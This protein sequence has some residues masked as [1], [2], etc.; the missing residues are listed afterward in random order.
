MGLLDKSFL[1]I[2][3]KAG[4][5]GAGIA[6]LGLI[7]KTGFGEFADGQ[8]VSAQT[9]AVL[10]STGGVAGVTAKSIQTLAGAIQ[11]K[12]GIDDEAIQAGQNLL[13]TFTNIRNETGKGNKIFDQATTAIT[14]MSVAL[15]QDMKS[16]A[17]QLGKALNSPIEGV[18]ALRR[19][20][21]SFT[22]GQRDAIKA[23][24]ESGNAMGAQKL[25]LAELTKEFGGSA[26]AAGTTLPGQIERGKRAFEELAGSI[27]GKVA[28]ALS[29]ALGPALAALPTVI[30]TAG[31]AI[32]G[33]MDILITTVTLPFKL[34]GA[35]ITGDWGKAW[36]AL[37]APAMAAVNLVKGVVGPLAPFVSGTWNAIKAG[38]TATWNAIKGGLEAVW[39]G[40]TTAVTTYFHA[41]AAVVTTVWNAIKGVTTGVWNAIKGVVSAAWEGIKTGITTYFNA[42]KAVVTGAWNAIQTAT[43]AVWGAIKGALGGIWSGIK[44]AI[45]TYFNAY[46]AVVAGV[47]NAVKDVTTSGWNA[48]KGAIAAIAGTITGVVRAAL[49]PIIGVVSGI[50][51]AINAIIGAAEA[52]A[53]AVRSI[54]HPFGAKPITTGRFEGKA[55]GGPVRKGM[56]YIVG[57]KGPEMF[58][59]NV[60]GKI[61]PKIQNLA[62]F[63]SSPT[64]A[65]A[66]AGAG[67]MPG[68]GMAMTR[69]GGGDLHVHLH[70][71]VFGGDR[72]KIADDL[73]ADMDRALAAR[74]LRVGRT[75][76]STSY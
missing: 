69:A 41:Y 38:T 57:E 71:P 16:S 66:G 75:Q 49:S 40:I 13:L 73:A 43:S 4:I 54:P 24:V 27:V 74:G 42:Y 37:K 26:E 44:T 17:I 34:I 55:L 68:G 11:A 51:G 72:R 10:K 28:P 45:T 46:K 36:D 35:L 23:M 20:G 76:L 30:A 39:G 22:K 61:L 50:M 64:L 70:G 58:L 21:V 9:A 52:A 32:G 8:K 2:S 65:M 62:E 48:I 59:P 67:R 33:A 12:T 19:V 31:A 15:G 25:I 1:G 53:S 14:D 5:A 56:P 63:A 7:A 6:G 29:S 3:A 60:A 18:T 47:W